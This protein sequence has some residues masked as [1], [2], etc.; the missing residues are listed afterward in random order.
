[1]CA[2]VLRCCCRCCC[3]VRQFWKR[4][5]I[6]LCRAKSSFLVNA[7][8]AFNTGSYSPLKVVKIQKEN[9]K[10]NQ[11][12]EIF[13]NMCS[14]W[15]FFVLL[16]IMYWAVSETTKACNVSAQCSN[17]SSK[18]II[19]SSIK[20]INK[21]STKRNKQ[22]YLSYDFV[23]FNGFLHTSWSSRDDLMCVCRYKYYFLKFYLCRLWIVYFWLVVLPFPFPLRAF[24]VARI[25]IQHPISIDKR[26]HQIAH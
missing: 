25:Y 2:F 15:Y 23:P 26:Q 13:I 3:C 8:H 10:K 20:E 12:L 22:I 11:P 19:S 6:A 17:R 14:E 5:I 24:T 7:I 9:T 4:N 1:M 18:N 21:N 16:E